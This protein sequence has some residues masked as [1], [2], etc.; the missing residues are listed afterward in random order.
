MARRTAE[1]RHKDISLMDAAETTSSGSLRFC[2]YKWN[3]QDNVE[4]VTN[5]TYNF[6]HNMNVF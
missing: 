3:M 4:T 1:F 6:C 5:T 2:I